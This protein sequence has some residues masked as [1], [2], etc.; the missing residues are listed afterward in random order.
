MKKLISKL[1]ATSFVRRSIEE[2]ADLSAF[3]ERP[4]LRVI[5]GISTIVLS[6]VI[7][8]PLVG[9]LGTLSIYYAEPLY[10]V[11]GGPAA[12]GLSHLIFLLGMYLAGAQYSRI[13]FRWLTRVT[14]LKL[15]QKYPDTESSSS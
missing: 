1:A 2:K 9:L 11:L 4:S 5:A 12:Y 13:F 10:V 8:W 15:I 7:G 14:I 6:F 3:K